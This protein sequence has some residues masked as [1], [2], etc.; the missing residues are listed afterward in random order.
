[1]PEGN[2]LHGVAEFDASAGVSARASAAAE[3]MAQLGK[4]IQSSSK[5]HALTVATGEGLPALPK[6]MV[7]KII[8]GEYVDFFE[9]PPAK[10][11]SKGPPQALEGQVVIIQAAELNSS[12]KV[13]PDLATWSQCFNLYAA[14]L[15]KH[16]PGRARSLFAYSSLI[17]RCS[18]KYK[19]PSWVVY[20][21]NFRQEAAESGNVDWAKVDPSIYTQCFTGATQNSVEGWCKRCHSVEHVSDS[22]PSRP[23]PSNGSGYS[24]AG[25]SSNRRPALSGRKRAAPQSVHETCKRYNTYDGDCRFGE[26]CIFLHRCDNC[27]EPNHPVSKCLKPKKRVQ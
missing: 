4:S 11:K 25:F 21:Q 6:R 13:I 7:D 14:V 12:K 15:I 5:S 22:C 1:M 26:S 9:L 27:G 19:W 10:G 3:L 24:A 2:S 17:A 20:D 16:H 23:G 8:A 18:A